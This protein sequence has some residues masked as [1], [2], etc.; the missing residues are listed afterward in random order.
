MSYDSLDDPEKTYPFHFKMQGADTSL[1]SDVPQSG[2]YNGFFTLNGADEDEIWDAVRFEFVRNSEGSYNVEG[3]GFNPFGHY[4][5][6]GIFENG[7]LTINRIYDELDEPADDEKDEECSYGEEPS[8]YEYSSDEDED[9]TVDARRSKST[10]STEPVKSCSCKGGCL[11]CVAMS[12]SANR[13]NVEYES[14]FGRDFIDSAQRD[15]VPSGNASRKWKRKSNQKSKKVAKKEMQANAPRTVNVKVKI[16]EEFVGNENENLVA[17]LPTTSQSSWRQPD[18][19]FPGSNAEVVNDFLRGEDQCRV[20]DHFNSVRHAKNWA[21][22]YFNGGHGQGSGYSA[23]AVAGPGAS[24]LVIKESAASAKMKRQANAP[25][26]VNVK[27]KIG[28]EYVAVAG[29]NLKAVLPIKSTKWKKPHT[30]GRDFDEWIG[31]MTPVVERAKA[32]VNGKYLC[33]PPHT[34]HLIL[35]H[36]H[37]HIYFSIH[38]SSLQC[39][40]RYASSHGRFQSA[41][42][43]GS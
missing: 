31:D 39:C 19:D 33:L 23:I 42:I 17:E 29:E 18:A 41:D 20:F 36:S 9:A 37:T 7:M 25:R 22:K 38:R 3:R 24:V 4:I 5:I 40:I 6:A 43:G 35:K 16:G 26:I 34:R 2:T 14:F 15:T 11:D 32:I 8:E 28:E 27:V 13:S 21:K 10:V 1:P 30:V 12:K